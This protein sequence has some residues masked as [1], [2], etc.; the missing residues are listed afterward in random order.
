M[1]SDFGAFGRTKSLL[2]RMQCIGGG[3]G[4]LG[5]ELYCLL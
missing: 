1:V 3:G 2:C 4:K 5:G